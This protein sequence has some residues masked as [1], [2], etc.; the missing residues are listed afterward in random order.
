MPVNKHCEWCG[1]YSEGAFY[2]FIGEIEN[3]FFLNSP[4]ILRVDTQNKSVTLR[5]GQVMNYLGLT[6]PDQAVSV[7]D[8]I[9][10]IFC[11]EQCED[12]FIKKHSSFYRS[13]LH[14][15]TAVINNSKSGFFSPISVPVETL[16]HQSSQC[17]TCRGSFPNLNKSFTS[18]PITESKTLEGTLTKTPTEYLA[19]YQIGL[20]DMSENNP[21]GN[22]Y[23]FSIDLDRA[24]KTMF[25]SNECAFDH[26]R[27]KNN[28]VMFKNNML[29]G[30]LTSISPFTV[31]INEGLQNKYVYRP[32][33]IER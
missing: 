20:S 31:R 19:Q 18:R 29:T 10:H 14:L 16:Q 24:S 3:V 32:Q 9:P 33:K 22:W 12:D 4:F 17:E 21:K 6:A 8:F 7:L 13:D 28:F 27:M 2:R 25:C 26:A 15:M 11:S 1:Q 30:L 23:F 5:T